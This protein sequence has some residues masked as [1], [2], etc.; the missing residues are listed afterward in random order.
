MQRTDKTLELSAFG[1]VKAVALLWRSKNDANSVGGYVGLYIC[2]PSW[3]A[4][5]LLN[6]TAGTGRRNISDK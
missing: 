5:V 4:R 3:M 1:I 2:R 6:V